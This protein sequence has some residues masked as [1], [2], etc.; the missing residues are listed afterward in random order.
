MNSR[1]KTEDVHTTIILFLGN[2]RQSKTH[3][4]T[5][6]KEKWLISN[7]Y[8]NWNFQKRKKDQKI[9]HSL[10]SVFFGRV[11]RSRNTWGTFYV[12]H[13][14]TQSVKIKFNLVMVHSRKKE[15]E[16]WHFYTIPYN[17]LIQNVFLWQKRKCKLY[18]WKI[19]SC[20]CLFFFFWFP[21]SSI[22]KKD[23]EAFM[24]FR[25]KELRGKKEQ[26]KTRISQIIGIYLHSQ[27]NTVFSLYTV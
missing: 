11:S 15:K 1:N 23:F 19:I 18:V 10:E 16:I 27:N 20:F 25:K 13:I 5:A 7:D 21:L 26:D 12:A 2:E 9:N 4:G 22:L 3:W 14:S 8:L 17:K 24:K 6:F